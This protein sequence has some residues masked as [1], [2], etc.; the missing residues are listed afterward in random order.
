M[1]ETIL[2]VGTTIASA[3]AASV[4]ALPHTARPDSRVNGEARTIMKITHHDGASGRPRRHG[5][6]CA[7]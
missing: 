6:R 3:C 5:W 4:S 1:G 2:V 7:R